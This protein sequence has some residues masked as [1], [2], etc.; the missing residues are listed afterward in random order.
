MKND[1]ESCS[2]PETDEL[3]LIE[4]IKKNIR[5]QDIRGLNRNFEELGDILRDYKLQANQLKSLIEKY[6]A[7]KD[8]TRIGHEYFC[9]RCR[10][11]VWMN[12]RHCSFCG[13]KLTVD[14]V[15]WNYSGSGRST[16]E[17][18]QRS[19]GKRDL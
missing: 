12:N 10:N 6:E 16:Q 13:G 8:P 15:S 19:Y 17:R 9:P 4:L 11:R 2:L 7:P 5:E 14:R 3:R 1:D 18:K